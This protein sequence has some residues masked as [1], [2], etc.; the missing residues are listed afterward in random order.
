MS[1]RSA[2]RGAPAEQIAN[3]KREF[4]ARLVQGVLAT[5]QTE[6][7]DYELAW[8]RRE[9]PQFR[10]ADR[11]TDTFVWCGSYDRA[12][13]LFRAC[14]EEA[15]QPSFRSHAAQGGDP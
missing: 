15:G 14:C 10:L 11:N 2:R 8:V 4:S 6:E 5:Y 1:R 7:H 9:G 12:H 13:A 3:W